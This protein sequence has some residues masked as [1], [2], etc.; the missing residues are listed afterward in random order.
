V[1]YI[2]NLL[3][4]LCEYSCSR[5]SNFISQETIPLCRTDIIRLY[6]LQRPKFGLCRQYVSERK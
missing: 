3:N 5:G 2:G 6:Y 1:L 4:F